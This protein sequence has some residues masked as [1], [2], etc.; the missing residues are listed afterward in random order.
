M[1]ECSHA[2]D[3]ERFVF[4]QAEACETDNIS[5]FLMNCELDRYMAVN[6]TFVQFTRLL[7]QCSA[8][9]FYKGR[10][11]VDKSLRQCSL[12]QTDGILSEYYICHCDQLR[13][14]VLPASEVLPTGIFF[15]NLLHPFVRTLNM[16]GDD[17]CYI[18]PG[19]FNQIP[20]FKTC[21]YYREEMCWY[22][23]AL[24]VDYACLY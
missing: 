19:S 15:V 14:N 18:E 12:L 1:D 11:F 3:H 20:A 21:Y 24:F 13:S 10:Q 17:L 6:S 8:V 7:Q 16:R 4:H 5:T 2:I 22:A 23:Q 9:I